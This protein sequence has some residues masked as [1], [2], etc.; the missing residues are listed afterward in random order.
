MVGEEIIGRPNSLDRIQIPAALAFIAV[1]IFLFQG[2]GG[3]W[4]IGQL[5]VEEEAGFE[6][7]AFRHKRLPGF[8]TNN[9]QEWAGAEWTGVALRLDV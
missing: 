2:I 3:S 6:A 4:Q 8:S 1:T 7:L 5:V 9:R